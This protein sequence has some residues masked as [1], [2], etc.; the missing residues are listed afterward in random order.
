MKR[1]F[2]HPKRERLA[3]SW[4]GPH[5]ELASACGPHGSVGAVRR[6]YEKTPALLLGF[7]VY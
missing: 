2:I 5:S 4:A 1:S 7:F 3:V 6:I